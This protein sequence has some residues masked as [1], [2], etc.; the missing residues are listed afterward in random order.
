MGLQI[1]M[2][3]IFLTGNA[4]VATIVWGLYVVKTTKASTIGFA[5]MVASINILRGI[6]MIP[7][8]FLFMTRASFYEYNILNGIGQIGE[9]STFITLS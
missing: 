9:Y 2:V 5:G 4:I 8:G 6:I 7:V 1:R 3:T